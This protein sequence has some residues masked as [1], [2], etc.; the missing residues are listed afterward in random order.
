MCVIL[1][2]SNMEWILL[3][4]LDDLLHIYRSVGCELVF[5]AGTS[6]A[7]TIGFLKGMS[8]VRCSCP[9]CA[10]H[11]HTFKAHCSETAIGCLQIFYK[12]LARPVCHKSVS[13][14]ACSIFVVWTARLKV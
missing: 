7:L 11:T 5:Q 10:T 2:V 12:L 9:S 6:A 8:D 4:I 13:G 14:C 3:A 1:W